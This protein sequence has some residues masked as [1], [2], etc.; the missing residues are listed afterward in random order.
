MVRET[1]RVLT[2]GG[3]DRDRIHFD[4]ALLAVCKRA[5]GGS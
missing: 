3:I 5:G 1:L 4:D 2:K